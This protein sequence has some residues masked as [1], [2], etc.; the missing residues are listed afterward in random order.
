MTSDFFQQ[1]CEDQQ[2]VLQRSLSI[3]TDFEKYSDAFYQPRRSQRFEVTEQG[4]V[5]QWHVSK[6][7]IEYLTVH[8]AP[9]AEISSRESFD[10]LK[11]CAQ[12]GS[13]TYQ[14]AFV[15]AVIK[16]WGAVIYDLAR[17]RR[18]Q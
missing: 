4:S 11:L 3:E 17:G 6:H 8:I 1:K 2:P 14:I 9:D 16:R 12:S 7:A 15:L 10:S 5:S 13:V 18:D